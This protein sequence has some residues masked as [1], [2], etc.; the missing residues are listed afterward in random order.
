ME[1]NEEFQDELLA[2]ESI[3][4]SCLLPIS[5]QSFTYTLSIPDSSVRLN[6][7]FPLDYPNSA[8]TVLDA[9]GI[10]KTLAEDVLLSVAT[11]DVCI[12]SYMDLLKELV[13]I[14]A[15]QAAAERESKLQE[16]SDKE[17]PVM[18]NKSHY[19]AKTP[20]IQDEPWKPKFDWKESE[21]ITDRKSTFMAHATRVYSTEEV[22]EALEDLYMDKKVAKVSLFF[23]YSVLNT[24][25]TH[26]ENY[27]MS[28]RS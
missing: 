14:D 8:P 6:I 17:T 25:P 18:L 12:F 1:N 7:Q 10:D 15:E 3:Y 20:E 26:E 9:Y 16:E 19:V 2:L 21:P 4:P 5:E 13:D 27:Y 11:G 22:R 23:R 24:S 28:F